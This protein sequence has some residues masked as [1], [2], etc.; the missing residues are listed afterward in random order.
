VVPLRPLA[1]ILWGLINDIFRAENIVV[2]QARVRDSFTQLIA[3]ARAAGIE[4][5]LATEI[6]VRPPDTWSEKIQEWIGSVLG[7]ESY[8]DRIN[9]H[10]MDT[11]RWL[12]EVAARERLLLLD[13]QDA[14]GEP[15]GRRK[16]EYIDAD[17]SHI[18]PAG[19]DAL[20]KFATPIL[21]AHLARRAKS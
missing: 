19:Y 1:V 9:R 12:R 21:S 16:R 11:N 14:L 6:T 7:K 17:G 13:L 8:Q 5:I 15:G 4:P 10:V 3:R 20:T 18:T 2:S